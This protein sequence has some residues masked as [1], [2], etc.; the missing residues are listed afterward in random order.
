MIKKIASAVCCL[1]LSLGLTAC[2]TMSGFGKDV[3]KTG[4]AIQ[5]GAKK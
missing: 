4:E 5:K 1:I 3:S 2:N